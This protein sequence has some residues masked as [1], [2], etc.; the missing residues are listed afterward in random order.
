[1]YVYLNVYVIQQ[2]SFI[3]E[4][5]QQIFIP[6]VLEHHINLIS[7]EKENVES[8]PSRIHTIITALQNTKTFLLFLFFNTHS[9]GLKPQKPSL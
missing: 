6:K 4:N 3:T 5:K 7:H 8:F 2:Q 1:M 9:I